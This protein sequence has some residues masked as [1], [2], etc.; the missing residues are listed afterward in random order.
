L[1]TTIT[2]A[3]RLHVQPYLTAFF[4]TFLFEFTFFCVFCDIHAELDDIAGVDLVW[5]TVFIAFA[6]TIAIEKCSVRA[7][8]VLQVELQESDLL[9]DSHI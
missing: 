4:Q 2:K 7:F 6:K 3:T 9:I 1:K 8:S 5:Q